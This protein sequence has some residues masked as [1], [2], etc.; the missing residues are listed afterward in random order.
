MPDTD[1]TG[2]GGPLRTPETMVA[3]AFRNKELMRPLAASY[4]EDRLG[5][6]SVPWR[7]VCDQARARRCRST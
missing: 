4:E 6:P 3:S 5:I 1:R 7:Q 2:Y